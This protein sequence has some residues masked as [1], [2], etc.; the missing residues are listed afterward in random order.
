MCDG[1]AWG[2]QHGDD[3]MEMHWSGVRGVILRDSAGTTC[4]YAGV[5]QLM[6]GHGM[7]E[8]N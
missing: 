6:F 7:V 2:G 4:K 5:R 8:L 1:N 3:C